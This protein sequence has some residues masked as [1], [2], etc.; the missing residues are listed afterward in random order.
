MAKILSQKLRTRRHKR[1]RAKVSGTEKRPRL[2]VFRSNKHI[3]ASL[4]DDEKHQTL[5][6]AGDKEV[7]KIKSEKED[8][9][10]GKIA[11]AYKVGELIAQK[12]LK[13]KIETIV[14]DRGGYKYHGRVKALAD[15]AR[16]EGLKF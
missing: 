3:Y 10:S 4:I 16:K 8:K 2:C 1:V 5:L 13:N 11:L 9:I 14:F 12:A 6:V 7:K 15:G